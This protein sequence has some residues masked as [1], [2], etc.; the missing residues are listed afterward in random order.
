[1]SPRTQSR[2]RAKRIPRLRAEL[3]IA[4]TEAKVTRAVELVKAAPFYHILAKALNYHCFVPN[5]TSSHAGE[6]PP[7]TLRSSIRARHGH[8]RMDR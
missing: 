8:C 6:V 7:A 5:G 2:F 4:A 3:A 1:M